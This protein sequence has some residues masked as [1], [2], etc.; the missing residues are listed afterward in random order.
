MIQPHSLV[1]YRQE[2]LL[3]IVTHHTNFGYQPALLVDFDSSSVLGEKVVLDFGVLCV[4]VCG[5]SLNSGVAHG[6]SLLGYIKNSKIIHAGT[7]E[8][9]K[10]R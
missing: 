7:K 9:G 4:L 2:V 5:I 3:L 6:D 8:V 1:H 10:H